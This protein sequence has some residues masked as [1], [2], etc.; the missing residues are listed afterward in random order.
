MVLLFQATPTPSGDPLS[1]I[2]VLSKGSSIVLAVIIVGF[3]SGW[4][5]PGKTY[6]DSEKRNEK[7]EQ[8]VDEQAKVIQESLATTR[9]AMEILR[10][11]QDGGGHQRT[12]RPDG[13][14]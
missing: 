7:L 9:D 10:H 14:S 5:V 8:K 4:I 11:N 12:R 2:D 1:L 13:N 6:Q 3:I